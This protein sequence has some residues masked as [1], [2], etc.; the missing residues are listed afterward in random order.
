MN[1]PLHTEFFI[2]T[3]CV[4]SVLDLIIN[5]AKI[6]ATLVAEAVKSLLAMQET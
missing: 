3:E 6:R 1:A 4:W 2:Y 5:T